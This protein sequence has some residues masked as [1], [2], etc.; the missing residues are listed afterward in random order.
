[1]KSGILIALSKIYIYKSLTTNNKIFIDYRVY[2][3]QIL[4]KIIQS[5]IEIRAILLILKR[6]GVIFNFLITNHLFDQLSHW[7]RCG[8]PY[9][10]YSLIEHSLILRYSKKLRR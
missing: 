8:D 7:L 3:P 5:F 4:L 2:L 1:M 9:D 10:Q 6:V